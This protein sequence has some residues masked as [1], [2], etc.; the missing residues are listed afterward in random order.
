MA[1][2][3][4]GGTGAVAPRPVVLHHPSVSYNCCLET[5]PPPAPPLPPPCLSEGTFSCG[6]KLR[7]DAEDTG[8]DAQNASWLIFSASAS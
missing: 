6:L 3:P 4:S 7:G 5:P 8:L 1:P 2:F